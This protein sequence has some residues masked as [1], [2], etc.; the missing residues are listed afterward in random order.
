MYYPHVAGLRRESPVK[1]LA[2]LQLL[3]DSD[4]LAGQ[5]Y[6]PHPTYGN[7]L[8]FGLTFSQAVG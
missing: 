8:C 3:T 7:L 6:H 5:G 1:L 4:I 2:I